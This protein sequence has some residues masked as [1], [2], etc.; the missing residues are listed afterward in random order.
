M[1]HALGSAGVLGS[2]RPDF[3]RPVLFFGDPPGAERAAEQRSWQRAGA[4]RT[5]FQSVSSEGRTEE[6]RRFYGH[7]HRWK[8]C[9]TSSSGI[10]ALR[11]PRKPRIAARVNTARETRFRHRVLPHHPAIRGTI[12]D[13][14]IRR[15]H[16]QDMPI[17]SSTRCGF[18]RKKAG[19]T[20]LEA[21]VA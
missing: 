6:L 3:L 5:P 21:Q 8:N 20:Q 18:E 13:P 14:A 12:P 9:R 1:L 2:R 19:D 16:A 4:P 7:F 10:R 11:A 15:R 17:A